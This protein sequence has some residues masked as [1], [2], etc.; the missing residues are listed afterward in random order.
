MDFERINRSYNAVFRPERLSIGVVVPIERYDR[1]PVPTMQDHLKRVQLIEA[2]G[3]QA[4]W[5][6]DIPF[7]VPSFGDAGQTY[8]PFTYL[9]F[10]AG[11]TQRIA[12]G[13]ASIALP[14]HHPAHVAKSAATIDQLSGGRL[15]LGV[16]SGDRYDEYPALGLPYEARGEHFREAFA[17]LRHL[18]E[19]FPVLE[20]NHYGTLK[21]HIDLLPKATA[22]KLPLLSTG[23]SQQELDFHAEH[24]DGWMNY[25]RNLH[26]QYFTVQQWREAVARFC[27]HAKPFMQP[28][29]VVLQAED[30]FPPQPI[31]LG[32][33]IGINPLLDYLHQLQDIGVNHIALNFRFNEMDL[34]ET[35][36]RIAHRVLP[37]FQA[38]TTKP[39]TA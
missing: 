26:H 16:A 19:D 32:F 30:D 5:I 7:N 14:L 38:A 29:Y 8:D 22:H 10:L 35:L 3:Y 11:Q 37:H 18:Q 27:E 2:L 17:Y 4:L 39:T 24:A 15:L 28:L 6:R 21:G 36:E 20:N 33:R 1:S 23:F 12:L 25:P 31:P 13:V 34:R 9:G